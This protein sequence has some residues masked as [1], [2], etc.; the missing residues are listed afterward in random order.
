MI[1]GAATFLTQWNYNYKISPRKYKIHRSMHPYVFFGISVYLPYRYSETIN[2]VLFS[3]SKSTNPYINMLIRIPGKL[4]IY[5]TS[6]LIGQLVARWYWVYKRSFNATKHTT[7]NTYY[8]MKVYSN[9]GPYKEASAFDEI[10]PK[11]VS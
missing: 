10:R 5:G 9:E 7:L 4:L 8:Y 2:T 3:L 1:F 11:L 6:I